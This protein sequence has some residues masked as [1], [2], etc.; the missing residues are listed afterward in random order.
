MKVLQCCIPILLIIF[1]IFG[2]YTRAFTKFQISV[3][4]NEIFG[5]QG[6]ATHRH[7][8]LLIF[9]AKNLVQ[10]DSSFSKP[11]MKMFPNLKK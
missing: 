2:E 1:Y 3:S 5:L 11:Y 10:E 7:K 9:F 4:S 6:K 8:V